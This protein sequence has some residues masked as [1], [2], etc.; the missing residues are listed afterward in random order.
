MNL[1]V[2]V[3]CSFTLA[4]HLFILE[5]T[6]YSIIALLGR[7]TS[8]EADYHLE[9]DYD[10]CCQEMCRANESCKSYDQI[11]QPSRD[12]YECRFYNK[13]YQVLKAEGEKLELIPR[14]QYYS[15]MYKGLTGCLEWWEMA[16]A[17]KKGEYPLEDGSMKW[18]F[19]FKS[20]Q[21]VYDRNYLRSGEGWY[22][23]NFEGV[24]IRQLCKIYDEKGWTV[25]QKILNP[26]KYQ[27]HKKTWQQYT[28]GFK[29]S[30]DDFWLGLT[31]L[32][33]MTRSKENELTIGV[34][35]EN[36]NWL[37]KELGEFNVDSEDNDFAMTAKNE[38]LP[39]FD[40]FDSDITVNMASR[41]KF[42][43]FDKDASQG[44]CMSENMFDGQ[45]TAGWM[46]KKGWCSNSN[47]MLYTNAKQP[48]RRTSSSQ[49]QIYIG[50][51]MMFREID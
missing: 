4:L 13:N 18:C 5:A 49:N 44:K 19:N 42:V 9:V 45:G 2:I 23:I 8:W 10:T 33:L 14:V 26:L 31:T 11:W 34:Q 32:N 35:A 20:C 7:P 6:H 3:L 12:I 50:S 28:D 1:F 37:G 48:M 38:R 47:W 16:G 21:E 41:S 46:K 25:F 27:F 40:E 22:E 36:G 51:F 43:T 17:R 39:N 29:E 24:M 30:E 15:K